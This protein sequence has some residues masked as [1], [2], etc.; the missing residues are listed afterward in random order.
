[1]SKEITIKELG[2]GRMCIEFTPR[3]KKMPAVEI[4][5]NQIIIDI[6]DA[7]HEVVMIGDANIQD[8]DKAT[9]MLTNNTSYTLEITK[10][11]IP[12]TP[13]LDIDRLTDVLSS[14][15]WFLKGYYWSGSISNKAIDLLANLRDK[16][17]ITWKRDNGLHEIRKRGKKKEIIDAAVEFLK[18][19][20]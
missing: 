18:K 3:Y 14:D 11:N 13:T 9:L 6:N 10:T 5:D 8:D 19:Q 7:P 2:N 12:K 1:M 16:K 15:T 17:L 20:C 4:T